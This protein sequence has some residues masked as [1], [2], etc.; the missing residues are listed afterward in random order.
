MR[1]H[2]TVI[3]EPNKTMP[4]AF[5]TKVLTDYNTAFG[6]A[7]PQANESS[8]H[9]QKFTSGDDDLT[10][11]LK[12][13]EEA[14]KSDR[15]FYNFLGVGDDDD[16]SVDSL[17]P[18]VLLTDGEEGDK[19]K[20]LLV[21]MLDGDFAKYDKEDDSDT[22]EYR[23]VDSYLKD[24]ISQ[25]V[26]IVNGDL[27]MLMNNLGKNK[28]KEDM[29][30]HLAPRGTVLLIPVEGEAIAFVDNDKSGQWDWGFATNSLGYKEEAK[31]ESKSDGKSKLTLKQKAT[32]VISKKEE[33]S[34]DEEKPEI[35]YAACLKHNM[36]SIKER[37]LW[38]APYKGMPYKES[39][40]WWTNHGKGP[41]PDVAGTIYAGFP[42]SELSANSTLRRFIEERMNKKPKQ[43][44]SDQGPEEPT[45]EPAVKTDEKKELSLLLSKEHKERWRTALK[46]NRIPLWTPGEF[47]K[48][49]EDYPR[50]TLQMQLTTDDLLLYSPRGLLNLAH[51]ASVYTLVMIIQDLQRRIL[52]DKK[53]VEGQEEEKEEEVLP[54][55]NANRPKMTLKQ[56]ALA[57]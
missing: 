22:N 44:D 43:A 20:T 1:K 27:A 26:E 18:F 16:I 51:D 39:R 11:K 5:K 36:L 35:K 48:A 46:N 55:A 40:N 15:V 19:E 9:Y 10:E 12:D 29:K 37:V 45:E 31:T 50:A 17:Q 30:E 54:A 57:K 42:A 2:L 52:L 7:S 14:Y 6:F 28:T 56:K 25:L 32:Q 3:R 47:K 13:V 49:E 38:A 23:L 41:I 4:E 33:K 24:K 21:A 8:I 34:P 53:V